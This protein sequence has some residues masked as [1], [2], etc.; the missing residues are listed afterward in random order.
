MIAYDVQD[1]GEGSDSSNCETPPQSSNADDHKHGLL[2]QHDGSA[3]QVLLKTNL[4][5][6]HG[7]VDFRASLA[8][9][10]S[11]ISSTY[12]HTLVFS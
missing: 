9:L 10:L 5:L 11:I 7:F 4:V 2:A 12:E 3:T 1:Y 8:N 6:F